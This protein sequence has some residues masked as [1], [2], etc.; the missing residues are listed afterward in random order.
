[1][2][3]K[4]NW[5]RE[6][7]FMGVKD[8]TLVV[9]GKNAIIRGDN[10][11]YK[12]TQH[13]ALQWLLFGKNSDGRSDFSVK[14]LDEN[15]NEI[16]FLETEVEAELIINQG[17]MG[18]RCLR[19]KKVLTENWVKS[20][21]QEKQE[22]KG[23]TTTYFFDEVPVGESE[24]KAKIS[25][26]IDKDTFKLITNPMYFNTQYKTGKL[27]DWQSRRV[28]LFEICGNL[29]DDEIIAATPKLA[30]LPE[31]LNGKSVD[32]R[33]AIIKLSISKIN[34]E[35]E[36]IGPK[37]NENQRLI[38]EIA[39]DYSETEKQL[40]E[41]KKSLDALDKQLSDAGTAV[42][43]LQ[44]KQRELYV[45]KGQLDRIKSRIDEEANKERKELLTEKQKLIDEKFAIDGNVRRAKEELETNKRHLKETNDYRG[46]LL[47]MY[48]MLSED[49]AKHQ[50]LQFAEPEDDNF[51]CP[52]CG[53]DLPEDAK[54]QK[55]KELRERFEKN[56]ALLIEGVEKDLKNNIANGNACKSKIQG[57]Q[58]KV[59]ETEANIPGAEERIQKIVS[60]FQ[61]I[62][63]ILSQPAKIPNYLVD[64]EFKTVSS[65]VDKLQL[66]LEKPIEDTTTAIRQQ[67]QE[68]QAQID[69][70]NYILN[71]KTVA[72][73]AKKRIEELKRQESDMAVQKSTLEGQ[74]FLMDEFVR[75]KAEILS[76]SINRRFKHV[77][78]KLFNIQI[79]G[80]L[81]ECCDTLVNTNGCWVP[82][83]DGNTAG[84]MNAGLDIVQSLIDFYSV[85]A[86]VFIDNA[87]AV[88]DIMP[89][90][91]QVIKLVKP[92]ITTEDDRQKY[93]RLNVELEG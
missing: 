63:E 15:N 56:K 50:A 77:R 75:A 24:Y 37:I 47:N 41:L 39:T 78:F 22:Y 69:R 68:I 23:N 27:S 31:I 49:R 33:K 43:E 92:E 29:S 80:N 87:E 86:P 44:K 35:V 45:L 2:E 8:Y 13:S 42:V 4:L 54:E 9:N 89:I 67:K 6:K 25:A 20:R 36:K 40:A 62:D 66:E 82:F 60:R 46:V 93:S 11:T 72:A 51:V 55:T 76:D 19:L 10:A 88:T 26:V 81:E 53:Q 21:G 48:K 12:S 38:P 79:N 59:T 3:I 70:C 74:L 83:A 91:A 16:H 65:Q 84:K 73:D 57:L 58:N 7:N 1:M 5:L 90:Q 71:N 32:D 85:S 14:P 28:K 30:R 34:E 61:E 64:S 52:T 18:G 17:T